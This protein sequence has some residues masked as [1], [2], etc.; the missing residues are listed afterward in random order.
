MQTNRQSP[1]YIRVPIACAAAVAG[2]LLGGC[3][4]PTEPPGPC[5][6]SKITQPQ[7]TGGQVPLVSSPIVVA[8]APSNC[9]AA[10]L[11]FYQGGVL[12]LRKLNPSSGASYDIPAGRTE[13]KLWGGA[14]VPADSKIVDVVAS[15]H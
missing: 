3:P 6:S 4:H 13:I 14:S 8:W 2:L 1:V 12:V 11:Q 15:S 5:L 9:Y 10:D 7:V